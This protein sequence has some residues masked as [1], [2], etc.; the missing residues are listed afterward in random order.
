MLNTQYSKEVLELIDEMPIRELFVKLELL[1]WQENTIKEIQGLLTGG[2]ISINGNSAVRRTCSFTFVAKDEEQ[3]NQ[4]IKLN[5]K[6]KLYIGLKNKLFSKYKYLG[7]ILWFKAGTYVFTNASFVHNASSLTVNVTAKDKMCLLNGDVGGVIP[8]TI[9]LHELTY[10]EE[11]LDENGTEIVNYYEQIL[12][13]QIIKELVNHYGEEKLQNIYINDIPDQARWLMA[14][15]GDSPIYFEKALDE[16]GKE[17][18]SGNISW[19]TPSADIIDDWQMFV[20]GDQIGYT[21]TNFTYPGELIANPGD[22]VCTILDKIKNMLGNFEYYYD[23]DG[24][25]IFQEIRNYQNNTYIPLTKLSEKDYQANFD[26]EETIYSFKKHRKLVSSFN[27]NP[28][29]G[30]IKNDFIVW[31][32][33][34]DDG[35][36]IRYHL[37]IDDKPDLAEDETLDWREF[38]YRYGLEAEETATDSGYYWK[39]L[40]A[41]WRKLYKDGEWNDAVFNDPASLDYYLDFINSDSVGYGQWS[42]NNIGRRTIAVVDN[43]CTCIY[44]T[45]VP[46][47]IF[48]NQKDNIADKLRQEGYTICQLSETMFDYMTVSSNNKS[49]YDKIRELMYQHL[50][51]N[52]SITINALPIYWLE[53]NRKIEVEDD[54][55]RIYGQ[56][57][58]KSI[59]L[60]LTYN[61]TMNIQATRA[62]SRI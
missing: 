19:T 2:N 41:E 56:Y 55:S 29:Y 4:F 27:N 45:N 49:C 59:S 5:T 35:L 58:I 60:P 57:M 38:L 1:D 7:D 15:Q 16:N 23:I 39:E 8:D 30:N 37:A 11:V 31:G 22:S 6:F 3:L 24:N 14:Y 13:H 9:I 43:D 34:K 28:N 62:L 54:S 25:F 61:G 33:S 18:Y 44:N 10:S 36:P 12:V 46:D 47:I 48:V 32:K 50:T 17:S 51:L 40:K 20:A 53:P 21:L 52:E 26:I 42:V